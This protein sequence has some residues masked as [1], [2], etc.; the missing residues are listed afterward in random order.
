MCLFDRGLKGELNFK[1]N[2]SVVLLTNM[3]QKVL[4]ISPGHASKYY[5]LLVA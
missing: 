1:P 2:A 4:T 3:L 5:C